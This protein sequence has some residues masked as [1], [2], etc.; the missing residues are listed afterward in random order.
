M[1]RQ[2]EEGEEFW[3]LHSVL[4]WLRFWVCGGQ[5]TILRTHG[6]AKALTSGPGSRGKEKGTGSHNPRRH[7]PTD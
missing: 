6:K 3:R 2:E 7:S 1:K 4:E 5:Q